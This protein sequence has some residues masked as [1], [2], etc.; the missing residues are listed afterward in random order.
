MVESRQPMVV[1]DTRAEPRWQ[2]L[3]ES[4]QV[5][6]WLAVPLLV[7]EQLVGLLTLNHSQPGIY[8][9]VSLDMVNTVAAQYQPL[10]GSAEGDGLHIDQ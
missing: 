5:R 1:A 8:S 2:N 10:S 3:P 9:Q 7:G 4:E 6:S